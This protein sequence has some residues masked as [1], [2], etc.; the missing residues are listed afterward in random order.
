MHGRYRASEPDARARSDAAPCHDDHAVCIRAPNNFV[1][2]TYLDQAPWPT[3][4]GKPNMCTTCTPLAP[5]NG[6]TTLCPFAS[7][8]R[9]PLLLRIVCSD[10]V[11]MSKSFVTKRVG[12]TTDRLN[13]SLAHC[14]T[15]THRDYCDIRLTHTTLANPVG[16]HDITIIVMCGQRMQ[17]LNL[18]GTKPS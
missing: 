2:R 15:S 18:I 14:G 7:A 3:L 9:A 10:V 16:L 13:A 12:Q 11:L 17:Q 4:S 5:H 8:A 6:M 1:P